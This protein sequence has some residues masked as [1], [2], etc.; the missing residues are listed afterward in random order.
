MIN[1]NMEAAPNADFAAR[2]TYAWQPNPQMGGQMD[3]SIAG[4]QIRA[5]VD[6][7]LQAKGF[8]QAA[9][10]Q[11]VNMLVD[12]RVVMRQQTELE[13]GVGWGGIQTYNYTTGTLIVILVDPSSGR[14]LWRGVAQSMVDPGNSGTGQGQNIQA[15]IQ[16][17]FA[18]FP[19]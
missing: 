16:K 5:A 7:A 13:G 14:F 11:M 6:Q 18:N 1:V 3:M 2:K 12:Y 4:Q 15:S 9:D 8:Q 17:M 10:G 19:K